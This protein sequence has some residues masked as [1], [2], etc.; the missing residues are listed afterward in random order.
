VP[1]FRT[2]ASH[3]KRYRRVIDYSSF[4]DDFYVNV[5]LNTEMDLPASRETVLFFF[6]QLRRKFPTMRNFYQREQGEFVL[7]EEKDQNIYRWAT[8]ESRRIYSAYVNPP[9]I[10]DAY[11][12]AVYVLDLVPHALSVAPLDCESLSFIFGFDFTYRGN[13]NQLIADA[14][15]IH[16]AFERLLEIPGASLMSNEPSIIVSLDND[17]RTRCR[18]SIESRTTP[19]Q[20]R[21]GEFPEDQL[22]VFV[23]VRHSGS[24]FGDETYVSILEK[25]RQHGQEIVDGY[26]VENIL[27]PLQQHIAIK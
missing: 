3:I 9:T 16:P 21:T 22:S 24:L 12:Q 10:D 18:I 27:Q 17:C 15:G 8:V 6:E 20:M 26:V 13:H 5:Q 25:L 7:E 23:V 1:P 14:L 11:D 19:Y 2:G 4:S